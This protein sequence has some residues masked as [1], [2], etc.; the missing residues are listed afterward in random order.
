MVVPQIFHIT[1]PAHSV[2]ELQGCDLIDL[3][4][5]IIDSSGSI[6]DNN[7]SDGSYDNW[8]LTLSFV[9]EVVY[10]ILTWLNFHHQLLI[11]NFNYVFTLLLIDN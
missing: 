6:R 2:A 1:Y 11:E 4:I 5:V 8:E 7:P 3:C 9:K 10:Y